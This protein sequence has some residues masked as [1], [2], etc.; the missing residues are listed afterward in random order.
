MKDGQDIYGT[1][2]YALLKTGDNSK[3][4]CR[5]D[6]LR[7]KALAD[8]N[9]PWHFSSDGQLWM[10]GL[11]FNP[12]KGL[13]IAPNLRLWNPADEALPNTTYAFLNLELKF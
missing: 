9:S 2:L 8:E 3:L 6:D 7:S 13:K 10:A 12:V 11:E 1:S 5:F 4:F